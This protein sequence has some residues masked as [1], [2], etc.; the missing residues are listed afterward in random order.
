VK[1]ALVVLPAL[2]ILASSAAS[3]AETRLLLFRDRLFV[4]VTVNGNRVIALL[5]SAAEMSV[6]D[7]GLARRLRLR[8]GTDQAVNGTGG[9]E[10][11]RFVHGLRIAAAGVS[12]PAMTAVELDL[13]DLSRRL[14]G[15]PVSLVLGREL[16]DA[17]RFRIDLA[18]LT[19]TSVSR[20]R[21]PAG[22]RFAL[23]TRRGIESFPVSIEGHAQAAAE[24]DLGNGSEVLVGKAYAEGIG[25]TAPG[26]IVGRAEGGGFGGRV[27]RDLIVLKSLR[28]GSRVFENVRA[29]IDATPNAAEINIGTAILKHFRITTDF[30]QHTLWLEPRA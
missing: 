8:P 29:A 19:L 25:L 21:A 13:G 11:G 30:P 12:L 3:A 15:R 10:K 2:L 24:F 17:G 5:D 27:T 1:R 22:E 20:S 26:R 7:D 23:V 6:I 4:P 18:H 28:I 16:F 9:A 14:I